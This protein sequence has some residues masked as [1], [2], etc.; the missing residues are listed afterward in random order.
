MMTKKNIVAVITAITNDRVIITEEA[1]QHV[2][3]QH[4]RIVPRD[5]LL[6]LIERILKDPTELYQAFC[7]FSRHI[8]HPLF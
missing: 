4:F 3:D 7:A 5:I 1:L 2:I 8:N 6:E